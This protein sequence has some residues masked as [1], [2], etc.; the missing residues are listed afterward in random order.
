MNQLVRINHDT[1][2]SA[3]SLAIKTF[4]T[5]DSTEKADDGYAFEQLNSHPKFA[6]FHHISRRVG[7]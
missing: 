7:K 4:A 1:S 2:N 6:D 3:K 5:A